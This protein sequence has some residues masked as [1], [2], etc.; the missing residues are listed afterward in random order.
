MP[1]TTPNYAIP[2]PCEGEAITTASFSAWALGVENALIQADAAATA[3]THEPQANLSAQSNTAVGVEGTLTFD[4]F[5][6]TLNMSNGITINAA[7]GTATVVFPGLYNVMVSIPG[8]ASTLTMTSQRM[9]VY[10]NGVLYAAKK[11][12][13]F[14]VASTITLS[15]SVDWDVGPLAAGDV[16]TIR[17]LWTG[18]GALSSTAFFD[19]AIAFLG[20]P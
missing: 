10:V 8:N 7:A 11:L 18:T 15:G 16:I 1:G 2:F 14:T 12:R 19:V 9:A 4:A 17:W 20:S 5:G 6:G 13:G 3:A